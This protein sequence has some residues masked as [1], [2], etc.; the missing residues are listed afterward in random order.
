MSHPWRPDRAVREARQSAQKI[1]LAGLGALALAEEQGPHLFESLVERG[2]E[3]ERRDLGPEADAEVAPASEVREPTVAYGGAGG[4][5]VPPGRAMADWIEAMTPAMVPT[6]AM[7]LQARRNS[8][9]RSALIQ[10][11]GVLT[12]SEIA[13]L[14]ESQAENRAAL[15]SRWKQ[16]GRIFSV[17]H[18]GQ[19][20]FPAFQ[21]EAAGRPKPAVA[22]VLRALGE[23]RG[24]ET[25]LWFTAANG[26]LDGRRP[27][28]H[29]ESDPDS[30]LEAA[31]AEG[32]EIVF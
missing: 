15:A 23:P 19:D 31:A 5:Q 18:Q 14:N 7:V 27:V 30:V 12:S 4:P 8:A 9:A 10:E 3:L 17:R 2:R 25:A 16:E 21:F 11:F 26:Y 29:L 20:Y 28:D 22:E 32:A 6:P 24:W 1:W 13:D